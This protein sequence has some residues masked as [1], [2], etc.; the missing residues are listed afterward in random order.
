MRKLII[1]YWWFWH[2]CH[3]MVLISFQ[4]TI[5]GRVTRTGSK[6]NHCSSLS[7][8]VAS[9]FAHPRGYICMTDSQKVTSICFL[10][11]WVQISPLMGPMKHQLLPRSFKR[12]LDRFLLLDI[13]ST[14]SC[15]QDIKTEICN[16]LIL[17]SRFLHFLTSQ[18]H[19]REQAKHN[20][21][22]ISN[23]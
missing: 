7:V 4:E 1:S 21:E 5:L 2:Q 23:R 20:Y 6:S 18:L 15:H 3:R 19:S 13:L 8:C 16:L 22:H 12:N 11:I 17:S 10:F 14:A 9:V